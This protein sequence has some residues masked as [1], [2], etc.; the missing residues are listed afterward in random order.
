[1]NYFSFEKKTKKLLNVESATYEYLFIVNVIYG[2]AQLP[3]IR[4]IYVTFSTPS[5]DVVFRRQ[6]F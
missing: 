5:L 3:T 6:Q 1:M 4:L 2:S